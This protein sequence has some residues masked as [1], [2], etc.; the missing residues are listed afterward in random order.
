MNTD[1]LTKQL[2]ERLS[3]IEQRAQE[4]L[5]TQHSDSYMSYINSAP[6]NGFRSAALSFLKS[7]FGV[8]N[9]YYEEFERKTQ[10]ATHSELLSAIE[11]LKS[12]RV[13]IENNWLC[14]LKGLISAEIFSDFFEMAEHLLDNNYKDAS[15]VII[16]SVLEEHLR[17]LCSKNGI[18]TTYEKNGDLIPK[19]TDRINS[20]LASVDIYNKLDQKNVTAWLDLRNKAAHGLYSDYEIGQVKIMYSGVSDFIT[21]NQI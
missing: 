6:F 5:A 13:E 12:L 21:R 7:T 10:R 11:I 20:D 18:E 8:S 19:K 4:T 14:S 2:L 16:G 15:A 3:Y 1:K 17:Q 9:S